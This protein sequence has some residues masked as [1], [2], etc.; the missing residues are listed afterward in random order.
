F[1]YA[2]STFFKLFSFRL[3]SGNA[4]TALTSP[5]NVLL[6]ESTAKKY[7]GGAGAEGYRGVIGKELQIANDSIPYQ[8]TGIIQDC[9][10]NSQIKFDLLASFSSLG[11]EKE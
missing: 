5:H 9:P 7:F 10:S 1:M 4:N 8:V 2:D 11:L 6:T 3:L